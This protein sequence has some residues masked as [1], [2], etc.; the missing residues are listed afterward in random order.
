[1]SYRRPTGA[2]NGQRLRGQNGSENLFSDPEALEDL[3]DSGSELSDPSGKSRVVVVRDR[4][5]VTPSGEISSDILGGMINRATVALVE[6]PNLAK[7]FG[8]LFKPDDIVLM[9]LA[10]AAHPSVIE[11]LLRGLLT[12]GVK[13]KNV[14][15]YRTHRLG[16]NGDGNGNGCGLGGY[17]SRYGVRIASENYGHPPETIGRVK[18]KL[19][20]VFYEATAI[21]NI[22][23]L[24]NLEHEGLPVSLESNLSS[25]RESYKLRHNPLERL[26]LLN[27]LPVIRQKTRLIVCDALQPAF[28]FYGPDR[29]ARWNYCAI[30]MAHDP[31]A[32]D[33][34]VTAILGRHRAGLGLDGSMRQTRLA[35]SS[36]SAHGLGNHEHKHIDL[37][38]IDV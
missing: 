32:L 8:G 18:L 1:M 28:E 34:V 9:K 35:L 24:L 2:R 15:V 12:A 4:R 11:P 26:L 14:I 3:Q 21:V 27:S 33:T 31:V 10:E 37:L 7:A 30:V 16:S 23:G 36:A 13:S 5:C 19:A 38:E 6:E 20:D 29:A 17:A 25:V 22:P